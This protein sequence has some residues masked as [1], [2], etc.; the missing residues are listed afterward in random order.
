MEWPASTGP[1]DGSMLTPLFCWSQCYRV[2]DQLLP[3][4]ADAQR[5]GAKIYCDRSG[6][7]ACR[8]AELTSMNPVRPA[9]DPALLLGLIH[10]ILRDEKQND[11]F[12]LKKTVAPYLV[13]DDNGFSLA[14]E[15]WQGRTT[16]AL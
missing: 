8:C 14:H 16:I 1:E 7:Y 12:M 3:L 6:L 13:R 5:K 2:T 15:H 11:E 9:S 4:G 10:C